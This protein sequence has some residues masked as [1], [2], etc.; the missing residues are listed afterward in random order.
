MKIKSI[1]ILSLFLIAMTS[2]VAS[3]EVLLRPCKDMC[4]EECMM[5]ESLGCTWIDTPDYK[6]L[7]SVEEITVEPFIE[8]FTKK[9]IS[10]NKR[11]KKLCKKY[12]KRILKGKKINK[13]MQAQADKYEC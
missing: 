7:S 12:N 2:M 11:I 6:C 4:Y 8:K 10:K 13:I 9:E 1:I 5:F 3:D